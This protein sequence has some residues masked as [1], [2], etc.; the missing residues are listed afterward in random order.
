[1]YCRICDHKITKQ[2]SDKNF[3]KCLGCMKKTAHIALSLVL[4]D[5]KTMPRA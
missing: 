2:Q 4:P 3:G 1:M 5:K